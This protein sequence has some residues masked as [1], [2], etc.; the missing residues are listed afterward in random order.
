MFTW[1]WDRVALAS[2]YCWLWEDDYVLNGKKVQY[3][4]RNILFPSLVITGKMIHE[5]KV[6]L[7]ERKAKRA[8]AKWPRMI[9]CVYTRRVTLKLP[10]PVMVLT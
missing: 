6:R 2:P 1:L 7:R 3:V 10:Y 9:W 5:A 8:A 4:K